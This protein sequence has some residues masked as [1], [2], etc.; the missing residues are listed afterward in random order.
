ML[1]KKGITVLETREKLE[2]D[3]DKYQFGMS[4]RLEQDGKVIGKVKDKWSIWDELQKTKEQDILIRVKSGNATPFVLPQEN[5]PKFKQWLLE[6][7]G[8]TVLEKEVVQREK[9]ETDVDKYQF[10]NSW[11]L[12]QDGKNIGR[13]KK[14]IW[15]ELA[16]TDGQS[17]LIRV[18]A[19]SSTPF[20]L[21]QE[22]VLAFKKWLLE[23]KGITVI[24]AREKLETDI[25]RK[26]FGNSWRLTQDGKN[27][28]RDKKSIWDELAKTEGQDI[29]IKVKSGKHTAFILPQENVPAFKKWLLE[30]TKVIVKDTKQKK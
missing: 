11:R 28:G 13:D 23:K 15:D 24:E 12:K 1:E 29:L 3:V 8:I 5:I 19:G 2:T 9:L 18:K 10:E 14:S 25:D 21:P 6:E 16:K 27:I 4:W 22:N 30:I 7:K 20:V 26:I 17:I